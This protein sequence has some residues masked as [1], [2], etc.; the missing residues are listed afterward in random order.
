MRLSSYEIQKRSKYSVVLLQA[1]IRGDC[2]FFLALLSS[3]SSTAFIDCLRDVL[4]A[5]LLVS[6]YD[7][8]NPSP[9]TF[10]VLVSSSFRLKQV[11]KVK[12]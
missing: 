5:H 10:L 3:F 1:M 12:D 6:V 8:S 11:S 2:N 4:Y 7:I 9:A